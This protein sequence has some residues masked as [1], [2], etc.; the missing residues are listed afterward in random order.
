M[1]STVLGEAE[2]GRRGGDGGASLLE[3]VGTIV[4]AAVILAALWS[5]G[6]G[7]AMAKA[8]PPALCTILQTPKK[9]AGAPKKLAAG[10]PRPSAPASPAPTP[11]AP[12]K[13]VGT[14]KT[15]LAGKVTRTQGNP[16]GN[17]GQQ[18]VPDVKDAISRNP[19][20]RWI[21]K[22]ELKLAVM[23]GAR[24]SF[25]EIDLLSRLTPPDPAKL[26]E[27][28]YFDDVIAQKTAIDS[29]I[30]RNNGMFG[31]VDMSDD[32]AVRAYSSGVL[33]A[34]RDA[35]R[36]QVDPS[37]TQRDHAGQVAVR[38]YVVKHQSAWINPA[39]EKAHGH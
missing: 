37:T 39:W 35:S 30:A 28:T 12:G 15:T 19:F 25:E 20:D 29:A 33:W 3:Y 8:L 5:V 26:P 11:S 7:P 27:Q 13:Q 23:G 4:L 6:I 38:N 18:P 1:R 21:Q 10:S 34:Q 16:S 2:R 31:T 36:R 9:C 14:H 22:Q 24:S 17:P 32:P